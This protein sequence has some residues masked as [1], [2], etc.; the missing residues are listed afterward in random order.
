[1][2]DGDTA[3]VPVAASDLSSAVTRRWDAQRPAMVA[4]MVT[5]GVAKYLAAREA[6]KKGDKESEALG[7][8]AGRAVNLAGNV[9]ERADTRSWSLLPD[10]ISVARLTLPPGEHDVEIQVLAPDG[11]VAQTLDLGRV[12]LNAGATRIVHRRVWGAENGDF[13]RLAH[14]GPVVTAE[15]L[16]PLMGEP[17]LPAGEVR[18]P[19]DKRVRE[20]T[21]ARP[22]R[23]EVKGSGPVQAPRIP[24]FG[25]T[26]A[27]GEVRVPGA[28][29]RPR[30]E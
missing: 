8:L 13:E 20:R 21:A 30:P 3:G 17:P 15:E 11:S 6:E 2:L 12:S 26:R 18:A 29:G 22:E 25:P 24:V 16:A 28:S 4:R 27:P 10:R 7:W 23:G 9:M 1:M 14:A 19:R 5:R